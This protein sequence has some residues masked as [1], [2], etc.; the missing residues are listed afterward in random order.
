ML[1]KNLESSLC[2]NELTR[3]INIDNNRS[4]DN[5]IDNNDCDANIDSNSIKYDQLGEE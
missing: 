4:D 5:D 1:T 2:Q 3:P